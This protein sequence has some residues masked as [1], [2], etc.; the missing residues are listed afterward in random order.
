MD[1]MAWLQCLENT[2][3]EEAADSFDKC[4]YSQINKPDAECKNKDSGSA[5]FN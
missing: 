5:I 3:D 1:A 2:S 4:K